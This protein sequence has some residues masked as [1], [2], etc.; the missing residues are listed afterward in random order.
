[1]SIQLE[2]W[3]KK[4]TKCFIE[5]ALYKYISHPVP[6]LYGKNNQGT[7][8]KYLLNKQLLSYLIFYKHTQKCILVSTQDF[9]EITTRQ[10]L[11]DKIK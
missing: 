4:L 9:T 8:T 10:D 5:Q 11:I 7:Y 1:M 2:F 6:K 3:E